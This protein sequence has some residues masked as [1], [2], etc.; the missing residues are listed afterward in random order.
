MTDAVPLPTQDPLLRAPDL[1]LATLER[2]WAAFGA[3][4]PVSGE[5]MRGIDRRAQRLGVSGE[6]LMEEA[7]TAVG[8]VARVLLGTG[9]DRRTGPVLVLAGPGNNGGDGHVAARWLADHGIR[10][11]VALVAADD[12]PTTRDAALQWDR[13]DGLD[14][15]ERLHIATAHEARLLLNGI[16][17]AGLVIDALLGTGVRGALR[18]PIRSAVDVARR[19]RRSGVPVLAVDTPTAVDPTS[20]APSDPVV[21]ANVTI[22]FHR[23]RTGL[24]TA[25]AARLA[26]RE[27]VAPIGIP[28][29]A[30]RQ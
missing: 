3:R 18:E 15:V 30:D 7:G 9:D 10:S 12:R 22:T 8:A 5:A 13:L 29:E 20:G 1:D 6:S 23:P 16:E 4:A 25:L 27:L 2:H 28:A 19:A 11:V 21:V 26:G 24:R 14:E 17:R